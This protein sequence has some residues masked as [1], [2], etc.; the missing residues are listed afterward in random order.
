M[1]DRR[2]VLRLKSCRRPLTFEEAS[3]KRRG[4][5]GREGEA[6]EGTKK[7]RGAKGEEK[8]KEG[9]KKKRQRGERRVR[10]GGGT[11]L[12]SLTQMRK[13]G[14]SQRKNKMEITCFNL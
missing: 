2:V 14:T 9:G 13:K 3:G 10:V 6:E 1:S 8:Q 7:Y 4:G 12:Q 5:E 11:S